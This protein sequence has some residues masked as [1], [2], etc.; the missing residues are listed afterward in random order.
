MVWAWP[1]FMIG[2]FE[3]FDP[4]RDGFYTRDERL[5]LSAQLVAEIQ[6]ERFDG[7]IPWLQAT[8]AAQVPRSMTEW[9]KDSFGQPTM[10]DLLSKLSMPIGLF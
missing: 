3:V 2:L 8:A 10:W 1:F 9:V 5:A 7:F 4:N 6:A